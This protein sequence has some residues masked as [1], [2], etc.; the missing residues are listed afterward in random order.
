[1]T[2]KTRKI[3][4]AVLL[5]VTIV[6][7]ALGAFGVINGM[8]QKEV[9]DLN[10]T[11]ITPSGGTFSIWSV[12]YTLLI[13]S[14]VVLFVKKATTTLKKSPRRPLFCFGSAA[15]SISPGSSRSP[16]N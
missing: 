9:S 3:I 7:N 6:L 15:F 2:N 10:D 5:V 14:V 16:M 13:A 12:L 11:L 1:M 4:N 8:T